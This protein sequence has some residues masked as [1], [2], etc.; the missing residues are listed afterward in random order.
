MPAAMSALPSPQARALAFI[1]IIVSGVIG[2]LIGAGFAKK[3]CTG[4]CATPIAAGALVGSVL[5]A[6]GTA[7]VAVLALRALGEWKNRPQL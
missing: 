1:G 5:I 7:V 2:G 4:S 6:L 3:Q